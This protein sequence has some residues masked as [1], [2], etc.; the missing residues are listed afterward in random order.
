[1][2]VSNNYEISSGLPIRATGY[3]SVQSDRYGG[4]G[5]SYYWLGQGSPTEF[6]MSA[7]TLLN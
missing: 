4:G 6:T 7:P 5:G 3:S 1:M 2:S